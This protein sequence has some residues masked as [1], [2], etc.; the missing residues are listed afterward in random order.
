MQYLTHHHVSQC[1]RCASGVRQQSCRP[2]AC[3][4][5][6]FLHTHS[7]LYMRHEGVDFSVISCSSAISAAPFHGLRPRFSLVQVIFLSRLLYFRESP[8]EI[9]VDV[10]ATGH[11]IVNPVRDAFVLA[12]HAL[13]AYFH[14]LWQTNS[15]ATKF[16][17]VN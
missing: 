7:R 3:H 1:R 10:V 15:L 4:F 13:T 9:Q 8:R 2:L 12:W 16:S 14:R 11:T 5:A 17:N 6:S